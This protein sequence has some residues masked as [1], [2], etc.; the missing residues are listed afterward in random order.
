MGHVK[1]C[2]KFTQAFHTWNR[3]LLT[4]WSLDHCLTTEI[5]VH[6]FLTKL[7]TMLVF[8]KPQQYTGWWQFKYVLFSSLF[9]EVIQFY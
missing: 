5:G 8:F 6:F 9:G 4:R 1:K 2:Q 7:Y 3:F